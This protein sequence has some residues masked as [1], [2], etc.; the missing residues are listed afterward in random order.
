MT[1]LSKALPCCFER[2]ALRIGTP[3]SGCSLSAA[4]LLLAAN[5]SLSLPAPAMLPSHCVSDVLSAKRERGVEEQGVVKWNVNV[6]C[7][8]M[9]YV[10]AVCCIHMP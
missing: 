5:A 3:S 10:C 7:V 1:S 9:V 8:N 6:E 2:C 4:H